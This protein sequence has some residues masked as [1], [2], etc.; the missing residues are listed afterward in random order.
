[1]DLKGKSLSVFGRRLR[2]PSLDK[3][4]PIH[5]P[6]KREEENLFLTGCLKGEILGL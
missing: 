1:V 4:T 2:K 6:F 3:I 5:S